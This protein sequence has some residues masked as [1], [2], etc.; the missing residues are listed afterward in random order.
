[1]KVEH[2]KAIP[3]QSSQMP[4]PSKSLL[5][6]YAYIDEISNSEWHSWC[7]LFFWLPRQRT[8]KGSRPSWTNS[9]P[10]HVQAE[11]EC[12]WQEVELYYQSQEYSSD[13]KDCCIFTGRNAW[14]MVGVYLQRDWEFLA[15][16]GYPGCWSLLSCQMEEPGQMA[17]PMSDGFRS[18]AANS[19]TA[20]RRRCPT[21]LQT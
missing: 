2:T 16:Y 8:S 11:E 19:G 1:M 4:Q 13:T 20:D 18:Q 6:A 10:A 12:L 3:T 17:S 14:E 9:W 21:R 15:E 5:Q 7:H